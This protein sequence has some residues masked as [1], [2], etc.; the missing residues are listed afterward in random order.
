MK[1]VAL[2][3][4]MAQMGS[5]VPASSA[6][7]GLVDQCFTRIGAADNLASGQS[8]FMVEM[9]ETATILH[10]ASPKSLILLDEIGRGTSTYDG[11]SIAG[12]VV[13]YI[14]SHIRARTLFATHY[15]ELT[16][17]TNECNHV[18]N[19]S[20]AIEEFQGKLAFTY[21]LIAGPADKSYGIHVAE[22]AGLPIAVVDH[23]SQLLAK[24]EDSNVTEEQLV[25]F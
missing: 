8:T 2:T 17:I 18:K 14:H 21:Q 4:I 15:H 24:L 10:N 20:M 25:L 23:A 7:I 6:K 13:Y 3:T 16:S 11:M 12:A 5:F 22:M 1:Q 9:T 19:M